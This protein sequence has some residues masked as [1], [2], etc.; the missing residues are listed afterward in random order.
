MKKPISFAVFLLLVAV[1]FE[2]CTSYRPPS[3][4][5]P[6]SCPALDTK[7]E[8]VRRFLTQKNILAGC[9]AGL[10]DCGGLTVGQAAEVNE[11]STCP[12]RKEEKPY[13]T[14]TTS[15][16]PDGLP[17]LCLAM[18][19]GGLRSAA[20]NIGVLQGLDD[21]G[22]LP[23]IDIMSS[24]SGGSYANYWF[25]A[26]QIEAKSRAGK[27]PHE[28]LME[29]GEE[30]D[31]LEKRDFVSKLSG[32][33]WFFGGSDLLFE[34]GIRP[35]DLALPSPSMFNFDYKKFIDSKFR[36]GNLESW[37]MS[38]KWRDLLRT[39]PFFIINATATKARC[40]SPCELN[41]FDNAFEL[42]PLRW[43]SWGMGFSWNDADDELMG[44]LDATAA[45]G[46]VLDI[47][48]LC[49][50]YFK[51]A[52]LQLRVPVY[53]FYSGGRWGGVLHNYWARMEQEAG[54]HPTEV[55]LSDGGGIDNTGMTP[56]VARLC[57]RII[58][59]DASSVPSA[60]GKQICDS[61]CPLRSVDQGLGVTPASDS[62]EQI[63]TIVN[64]ELTPAHLEIDDRA[65]RPSFAQMT[66]GDFPYPNSEAL[67]LKVYYIRLG[68]E[69]ELQSALTQFLLNEGN[70]Y[71]DVIK[72]LQN[73]PPET[74]FPDSPL[75][76][77]NFS[78]SEFRAYKAL[79][80]FLVHH[81]LE[82][83]PAELKSTP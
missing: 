15:N 65:P 25:H 74:Y 16:W 77:Q 63:M 8:Q 52:G 21:L 31:A 10:S 29:G 3:V 33:F 48:G 14:N 79:G 20:T 7:D 57:R 75:I 67:N 47:P 38:P 39:R 27:K 66:I 43:G 54:K 32:D 71:A 36:T 4:A 17:Q 58:A 12:F 64:K 22:L 73:I 50:S 6:E 19:G 70:K 82:N 28:L 56:L 9:R 60:G 13:Y 76:R 30:Q 37:A 18:S 53:P 46:A 42:T 23:K 11:L 41:A 35:I 81:Y 5:T 40:P 24:V 51:W 49:C 44:P 59:V 55:F 45:S 68:N 2:A 1:F 61:R 69:T 72:F 80:R 78:L 34:L 62:L 83:L 26:N